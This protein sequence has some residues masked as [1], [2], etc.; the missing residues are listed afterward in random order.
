MNTGIDAVTGA[1]G[2]TGKYIARRLFAQGRQVITLTGHP[3]RAN[4]FAGR[5]PAY[6][7]NFN[8][9]PALAA[10]LL[11]VDT[12]YNTYWVRFDH[13]QT[14]FA[15]AVRNTHSPSGVINPVSSAKGMKRTGRIM[16][17]F[18]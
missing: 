3:E 13:G 6:R 12:L 1:Y 8:D 10:S 5:V 7:F 14:T 11:D 2:Y 16:P 4:E 17:C 18:G 15:Q 9:P